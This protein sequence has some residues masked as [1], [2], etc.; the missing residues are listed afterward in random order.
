MIPGLKIGELTAPVAIIQGGMSVG[1]SLSGLASAVAREGGIGVIG[2]A[3]IGILE[4]DSLDFIERNNRALR[5]EIRRAYSMSNGIG[6]IGVNVMVALSNFD[7][8]V[9][10]AIEEKVDLIFA[11]AGLPLGLPV[12]AVKNMHTKL[13]PI[14]S[15]VRA[16]ELISR[17]WINKYHY[18]PDGFVIEGPMAGGHLGFRENEIEDLKFAIEGILPPLISLAQEL[19]DRYEKSIPVIAAGGIYSGSDIYKILKLG[20]SGVQ[21]G[22]RFVTTHECDASLEFKMAYIHSKKE[23]IKIIKSPVGLPGR[24]LRNVFID[25]VTAGKRKPYTCPFKCIITC[26]IKQS[27]Y[28]IALALT[29][30][31]KGDL[32]N[33]FVFCGANAYKSK[34]ITSVSDLMRTLESEF[35]EACNNRK[36]SNPHMQ[37]MISA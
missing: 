13:I 28:C 25:E 6:L 23:D 4:S 9:R 31:R 32:K 22:T 11:G 34:E 3:G 29:N 35:C 14:V 24:V 37:A 12:H 2:S 7:E 19:G 33:G 18:V 21:M 20:A 17:R 15:S 8:L 30:A 36:N 16:A 10:T 1:V 5:S 27:P 26:D